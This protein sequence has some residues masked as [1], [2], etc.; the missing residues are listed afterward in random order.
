MN[1]EININKLITTSDELEQIRN[2]LNNIFAK[3]ENTI[4][5]IKYAGSSLPDLSTANME[6]EITEARM[7]YLKELD[8]IKEIIDEKIQVIKKYNSEYTDYFTR[9]A[10]S[11]YNIDFR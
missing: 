10:T 3:L 9:I 11:I 5:K 4:S 7:H 2:K 8:E 6:R 1:E